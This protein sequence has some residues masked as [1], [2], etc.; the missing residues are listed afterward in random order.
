MWHKFANSDWK[1]ENI[2]EHFEKT[3]SCEIV[4]NNILI[5]GAVAGVSRVPYFKYTLSITPY[6]DGKIDFTLK[7][8]IRPTAYWLPRLGFEFTL[9]QDNAEFKYFGNG[10]YESYID[11]CHAGKI[12][13]YKSCADDE[14]I[15]YARPQEHGNH[16]N[17][18]MLQIGK[19][20]FEGDCFDCNI[21]SYNIENLIDAEHTDELFK[22][23]KTHLRIDYKVS[24]LGSNSCGPDL[25]KKY[26][27]CEK[28][29]D[30]KFSVSPISK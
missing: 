7:G 14:Y 30:F 19:L 8:N 13:L 11:M 15:N 1:T 22:D 9:P 26:C 4:D 25:D 16:T 27:L 17:T 12:G 5:H 3:Y 28:E 24:G 20:C 6:E 10:P 2:L 18:K 29:I 21:S 23:G